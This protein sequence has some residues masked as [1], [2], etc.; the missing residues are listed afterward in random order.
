MHTKH[1][2]KVWERIS[3]THSVCAFLVQISF[4]LSFSSRLFLTIKKMD[5]WKKKIDCKAHVSSL[6]L[7][8][9]KWTSCF[10]LGRRDIMGEDW[11]CKSNLLS[12]SLTCFAS[13][14]E[15]KR[16]VKYDVTG[17]VSLTVGLEI[18]Q[19]QAQTHVDGMYCCLCPS[20]CCLSVDA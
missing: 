18:T 15:G 5:E 8:I 10:A 3:F 1:I 19:Q 7:S 17:V 4:L 9:T 20:P 16:R 14:S 13:G 2:C 6:P 12:K 11:S